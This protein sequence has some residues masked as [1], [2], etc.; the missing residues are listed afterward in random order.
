MYPVILEKWIPFTIV[1]HAEHKN[2]SNLRNE[3]AIFLTF[4][5]PVML[6]TSKNMPAEWRFVQ[7]DNDTCTFSHLIINLQFDLNHRP[8]DED[9]SKKKKPILQQA[10]A[11]KSACNAGNLNKASSSNFLML[12]SFCRKPVLILRHWLEKSKNY[13]QSLVDNKVSSIVRNHP[14]PYM[15]CNQNN[16]IR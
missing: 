4:Y 12:S 1:S 5:N 11:G 8:E 10:Y 9:T 14:Y 7:Q 16:E 15:H 2:Q 3:N 13:L 6:F